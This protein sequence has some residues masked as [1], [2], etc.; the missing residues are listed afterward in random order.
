[1][2]LDPILVICYDINRISLRTFLRNTENLRF[3][4]V[5]MFGGEQKNL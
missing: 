4:L 2:P 3:K 5:F 1:M